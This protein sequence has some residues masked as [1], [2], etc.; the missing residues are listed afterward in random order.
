MWRRAA[1]VAVVGFVGALV[2]RGGDDLTPAEPRYRYGS[3]WLA[4]GWAMVIATLVASLIPAPIDL[5][6]GR[7]KASHL[8]AYGSLMFWFGMLYPGL[9]RQAPVALGFAAMGVGVEYLQWLTGYRSFEVADMLANGVGVVLG[10]GLAQTPLRRM[11][12]W[13][14]AH[15]G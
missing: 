12:L 9:R 6:E 13:V 3:V 7:D 5:S 4:L 2:S 8:V 10:W 11:L 14:E 15:L 1:Q